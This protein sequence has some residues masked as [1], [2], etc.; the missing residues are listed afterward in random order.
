MLAVKT[1]QQRYT[2]T[3]EVLYMLEQ[4]RRMLNRSVEIGL[5][6]NVSSLKSLSLRTYKHLAEYDAVSY[7]KLCAI[8][9]AAGILRNYR[10]AV[11]RGENP[12]KPYARRLRLTTCYGFKIQ[13]NA[14]MLPLRARERVRIPL[15]SHVRAAIEGYA[16]RSVTLTEERLALAYANHVEQVQPRGFMGIDRNL[17]NVTITMTDNTV[18]RQDLS[19]ATQVKATYRQIRSRLRRNDIRIRRR[20]SSKYGRKERERVKQIL[21]HASKLIVEQAKAKQF[22]IVM[23]KL[24]GLRRLYR[25]GNWQ[26]RWYRGRMNS[27]SYAELQRQITYKAAWNGIPVIYVSPHGTSA[28]CSMCGSRLARVP[29]ENRLLRCAMCGVTVDRDVNAARNILARG[30]RFV[31]FA[32][33][34]EAMVAESRTIGQSAKSMQAS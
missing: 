24:T 30:M 6:E 32:P 5:S 28:K 9:A 18:L 26:G 27:W 19:R 29:E 21:H 3:I 1:V 13:D 11:R 14:L 2:P 23:E 33:A 20:V 16:V 7:Y 17:D 34:I 10:K 25:R 12:C 8:S 15:T 4:F 31:P 22:G